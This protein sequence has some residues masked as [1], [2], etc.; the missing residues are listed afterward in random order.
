M[1][2]W[3]TLASVL[4]A[5]LSTRSPSV[6]HIRCNRLTTCTEAVFWTLMIRA[7]GRSFVSDD[8]YKSLQM[9]IIGRRSGLRLLFLSFERAET[10]LASHR[11]SQKF[12]L[13]VLL[14]WLLHGE[15]N[16][17]LNESRSLNPASASI[18]REQPRC[19]RGR[20]HR[21]P[22]QFRQSPRA[23][24]YYFLLSSPIL[25]W[26]VSYLRPFLPNGNHCQIGYN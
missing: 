22:R 25:I 20:C 24:A 11:C 14:L 9:Q 2:P 6:E 23:Q 7:S 17:L 19:S 13:T 3:V 15:C 8:A 21:W 18:R 1:S 16:Q 4:R 5:R 12:V 10:R 26:D